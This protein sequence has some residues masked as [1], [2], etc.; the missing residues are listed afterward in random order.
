MVQVQVQMELRWCSGSSQDTFGAL[1]LSK[2]QNPAAHLDELST[3]AGV[4]PAFGKIDSDTLLVTPKVVK[5]RLCELKAKL[6][7]F[8]T[9][10]Q[11]NL[12]ART[13]GE[14]PVTIRNMNAS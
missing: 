1:P 3:H 8:K 4:Y 12:K 10:Y 11:D 7:T 14:K 6:V 2:V 5:K 9:F 13:R